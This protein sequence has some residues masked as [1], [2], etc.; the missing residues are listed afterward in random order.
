MNTSWHSYPSLYNIG[1]AALIDLLKDNVLV[2]EKIDGSQFSFGIFGGELK[3]RSKG[4]EILLEAP[5]K[6]FLKAIEYV[7]SIKDS[8]KDGYTY[9]CEYLNKPKHNTLAYDRTPNNYL[10]IFDINSAEEQYLSYEDKKQEAARIGL[11]TVPMLFNGKLESYDVF[12]SF[13]SLNSI[14]GSQKIEGIVVKNYYQFDAKKKTLMGKFVSE[15]FKEIHQGDW[16]ERNPN[17]SEILAVISSKFKTPARWHKAV[18]HLTELGKLSG[19]PK[20]I[21]LL[22]SEV[23]LDIA[24]ECEEEIVSMLKAHFLPKIYRECTNGFPQWY[25]EELA[26]KQFE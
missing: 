15:A 25:K 20:D 18:Q 11:E 14:L 24:K 3:V 7:C 21:E 4:K 17:N 2:E 5:D 9:R 16:R 13:L 6:M 22:M 8:L 12:Q 10:I 23:P 26:K 1:H 19:T